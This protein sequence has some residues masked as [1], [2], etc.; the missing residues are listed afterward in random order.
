[1]K[2]SVIIPVYNEAPYLRRCFDSIRPKPDTEVIVIDDGSTDGSAEIC[3]EYADKFHIV[4][5]KNGGVSVARNKGIELAIGDYITFLDADDEYLYGSFDTM[6]HAIEKAP[7]ENI[8]QFNQQ[9]H[10]ANP[11]MTVPKYLNLEGFYRFDVRPQQWCMVWN[12]LY[13]RRF[14]LDNNIRFKEGLQYGE[15]EVFNLECLFK[16][17]AIWHSSDILLTRN[18]DNEQSLSHTISI[19]RLKAQDA[20]LHQLLDETKE[21]LFRVEILELLAEHHDSRT[22]KDMGW[23]EEA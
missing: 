19:E 1:M 5:Q 4:H 8:I 20:A 7:R 15:D 22:Y 3:D 16:N 13:K 12:K 9:R 14:I 23:K 18:F 2:I 21:P 11:G 6:L 10:Y 17:L